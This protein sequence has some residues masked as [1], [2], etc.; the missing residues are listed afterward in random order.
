MLPICSKT[1]GWAEVD[2]FWRFGD[3]AKGEEKDI[4]ISWPFALDREI[5]ASSKMTSFLA[6]HVE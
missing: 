3:F 5:C 4:S 2:D 1:V 6:L